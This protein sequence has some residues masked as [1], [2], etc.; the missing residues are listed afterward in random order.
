MGYDA[1][2]V[3]IGWVENAQRFFPFAY[4]LQ[5]HEIDIL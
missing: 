1:V 2:I 4:Q 3:F 5:E